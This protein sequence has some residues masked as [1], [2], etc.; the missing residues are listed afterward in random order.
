MQELYDWFKIAD[1]IEELTFPPTGL[2]ELEVNGNMICLSRFK[3]Q[4]L[5][6]AARCPHASGRLADGY[7]DGLGNIVCPI[8]RYKFNLEN[9]RNTSGEGYYLK[10]Y[11]IETREHGIF[12]GI[13]KEG[14][15][16]WLK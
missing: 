10:N 2:T 15:F 13:K 3:D 1:S 4:L 8:H 5:A 14:L 16:S 6:C 9:G 12:L 11:P 7:V